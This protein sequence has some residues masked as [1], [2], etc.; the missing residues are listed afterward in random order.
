MSSP[1]GQ[2]LKIAGVGNPTDVWIAEAAR[3]CAAANQTSHSA[4]AVG[5]TAD[6]VQ[7]RLH[8]L[9]D[10]VRGGAAPTGDERETLIDVTMARVLRMNAGRASSGG[11]LEP[12]LTPMDEEA[13][14]AWVFAGFDASRVP[15]S[16]R[17]RVEKHAALAETLAA[18]RDASETLAHQTSTNANASTNLVDRTM[19]TIAGLNTDPIPI[20][21][22]RWLSR[23]RL[24][25]A[26][27]VAAAVVVFSAVV[28]PMSSALRQGSIRAACQA[29]LQ[30]VAQALGSYAKTYQG[31]LPVAAASL[32]G[33][34]WD[35][36]TRNSNFTNLTKLASEGFTELR[37]LACPGSDSHASVVSRL[38][39]GRAES[40]EA[41]SDLWPSVETISYS[42]QVVTGTHRPRW[43]EHSSRVGVMGDR[44]PVVLRALRNEAVDPWENSPNHGGYGQEILFADGS[45]R[46]LESPELERGTT[47][48]VDNIW[49]PRK[50]EQVIRF[51]QTGQRPNLLRGDEQPEA[52]DTFLAP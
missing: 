14:D 18:G 3:E 5:S 41:A 27:A 29:N 8:R 50:I 9:G 11:S 6:V 7:S 21:R 39:S 35:S 17:S 42:Y 32:G 47:G 38:A 19:F 2:S 49:L 30:T 31:S 46:W 40:P 12:R 4:G 43:G 25:D 37:S 44:S 36:G 10:L 51:V 45:A 13:A 20:S 24:T 28:W 22:G 26:I 15:A 16:L 48:E 33:G 1:Q 34:W 23:Y 52:E